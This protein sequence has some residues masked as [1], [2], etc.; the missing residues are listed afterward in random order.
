MTMMQNGGLALQP[1]RLPRAEKRPRWLIWGVAAGVVV[2]LLVVPL[3]YVALGSIGPVS[4]SELVGSWVS[5]D[6]LTTS[7]IE[8]RGDGTAK[9]GAL[10]V[11]NNDGTALTFVG[12]WAEA[13]PGKVVLATNEPLDGVDWEIT[14]LTRRSLFQPR[15]VSY[16]ELNEQPR[17]AHVFSRN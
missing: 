13:A 16:D 15:L 9:V 14:V 12:R 5:A 1:P 2:I 11:P 6:G 4:R 17:S 10:E 3:G 8:L 7:T